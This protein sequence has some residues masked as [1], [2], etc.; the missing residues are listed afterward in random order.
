MKNYI[1]PQTEIIAGYIIHQIAV[2]TNDSEGDGNEF[3][4]GTSF[5]AFEDSITKGSQ[6][7]WAE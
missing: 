7:L 4:N 2:S 1:K 6:S 5:E 3:A